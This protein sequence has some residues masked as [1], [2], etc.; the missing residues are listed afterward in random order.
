MLHCQKSTVLFKKEPVG[1]SQMQVNSQ[2][3]SK[4]LRQKSIK[5]LKSLE[6]ISEGSELL[7]QILQWPGRWR[8]NVVGIR[9]LDVVELTLLT[10]D[11]K[12][13]MLW[14]RDNLINV[15]V[16]RFY[17][18]T[19]L[20]GGRY[21]IE[22]FCSKG[23]VLDVLQNNKFNLNTDF[24]MSVALEIAS[25]MAFLHVN[26]LVHGMLRSTCCMLDNKWTVKI[27][28]WEYL[29]LLSIQNPKQNPMQA[30]RTKGTSGDK[31][32]L[33]FRHIPIYTL[34]ITTNNMRY[35]KNNA[36]LSINIATIPSD[37]ILTSTI[38]PGDKKSFISIGILSS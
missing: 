31:Y 7:S 6:E 8:A 24:K 38:I 19:D 32:E 34:A 10:R 12:K 1:A 36:F 21:V 14:M 26:D 3:K 18:L 9:L 33:L 16:V 4:L 5:S 29:K 30:L 22:D 35:I 23:T 11:M 13:T 27:G 15:N 25:G 37:T 2:G 17:G 20:H 28:D